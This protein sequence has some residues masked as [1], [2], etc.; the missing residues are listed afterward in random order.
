[1]MFAARMKNGIASSGKL[2]SPAKMRCGRIESGML[3]VSQKTR[4]AVPI[5]TTNIGM[6]KNR[7]E[8]SRPR[9]NTGVMS[10]VRPF[11]SIL[12][13]NGGLVFLQYRPPENLSRAQEHEGE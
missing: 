2:S 11:V 9:I 3:V 6:A 7:P 12:E 5:I 1:M 10:L 8:A 13:V 4:N